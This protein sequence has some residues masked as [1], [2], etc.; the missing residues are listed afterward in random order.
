MG[1]CCVKKKAT[2]D[3]DQDSHHN[4]S[5]NRPMELRSS[6]GARKVKSKDIRK[7][8]M[9]NNFMQEY[10][11]IK[12]L[13]HGSW[14][15]VVQAK[16]IQTGII[17]AV[18]II[19]KDRMNTNEGSKRLL[20]QEVEVLQQLDHPCIVRVLDILEDDRNM[21]IV[22][23]LLNEEL[24]KRLEK[25]RNFTERDAAVVFQQILLALNYLHLKNIVHRDI[26]L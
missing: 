20:Y 9:I 26:K 21:Y 5:P 6:R 15:Q 3:E 22:M 16:D 7:V 14:G 24:A 19:G 10:E 12:H 17:C 18:K 13:G 23:E 11:V 4:P 1:Q 2:S 8:K 25:R